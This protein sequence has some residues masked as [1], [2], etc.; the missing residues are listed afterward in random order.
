M[1]I[2]G[3]EDFIGGGSGGVN[4]WNDCVGHGTHVAG[5]WNHR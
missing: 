3:G 5:T 1:N 2:A 4:E